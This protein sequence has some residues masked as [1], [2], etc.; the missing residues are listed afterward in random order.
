MLFPISLLMK[1]YYLDIILSK[2]LILY[3]YGR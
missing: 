2:D 3:H 1:E